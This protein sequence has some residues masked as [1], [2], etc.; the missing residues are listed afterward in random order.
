M[1]RVIYVVSLVG[2]GWVVYVC[3]VSLAGVV[4]D[5]GFVFCFSSCFRVR[6]RWGHFPFSSG[7]VGWLGVQSKAA[8]GVFLFGRSAGGGVM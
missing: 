8:I 6:P 4:L 7:T 5:R 1:F 3:C 2:G